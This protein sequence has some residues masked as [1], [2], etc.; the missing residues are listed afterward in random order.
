LQPKDVS[1]EFVLFMGILDQNKSPY[2]DMNIAQFASAPESASR[3]GI[4][5]GLDSIA[6]KALPLAA[7]HVHLEVAKALM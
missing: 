5:N 7:I 1:R 3:V 4:R 6:K 2:L